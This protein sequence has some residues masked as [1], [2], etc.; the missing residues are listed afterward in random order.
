M[1]N[2]VGSDEINHGFG[3]LGI[4]ERVRLLNGHTQIVTSSGKGFKI[5]INI[6]SQNEH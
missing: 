5:K 6:P 3:L 1:D 2:G 4:Q